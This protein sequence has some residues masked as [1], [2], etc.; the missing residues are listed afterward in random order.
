MHEKYMSQACQERLQVNRSGSAVSSLDV[1]S[2]GI[3]K[4]LDTIDEWIS[5]CNGIRSQRI[6]S[7][8]HPSYMQIMS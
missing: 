7:A 2:D 3:A 6:L 1:S 5:V 8:A 4:V